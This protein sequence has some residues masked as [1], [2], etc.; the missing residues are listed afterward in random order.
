MLHLLKKKTQEISCNYLLS[1]LTK[2]S[3]LFPFYVINRWLSTKILASVV[4][5]HVKAKKQTELGLFVLT[6]DNTLA[7]FP[8]LR[9]CMP[10]LDITAAGSDSAE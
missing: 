4:I 10:K 5:F 3:K 1:E 9:K 8:H 6:H 2:D 7:L